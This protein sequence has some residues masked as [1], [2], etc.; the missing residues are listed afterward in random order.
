MSAEKP[1]KQGW[2]AVDESRW[3]SLLPEVEAIA[4][5]ARLQI[6]GV[7]TM[8]PLSLNPDDARGWFRRLRRLRD[9]L[10]AAVP[11]AAWDELS[12][13][14]SADFEVAVEEGA[15]LVRIGQAILGPRPAGEAA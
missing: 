14:T 8:P 5:L 12:M 6:R 11:S 10:A 9:F 7:M 1:T 15:T 2:L 4:G 13:G 3:P